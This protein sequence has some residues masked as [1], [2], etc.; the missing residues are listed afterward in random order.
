MLRNDQITRPMAAIETFGSRQRRTGEELVEAIP[1]DFPN[2]FRTIWRDL[3]AL[4]LAGFPS[5]TEHANGQT[6]R[7]LMGRR[8]EA[9]FSNTA[10]AW[11][12][13]SFVN[14]PRKTRKR[15]KACTI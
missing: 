9:E 4:E 12:K 11:S 3:E 7:R 14:Y 1:D 6:W 15:V 2:N 5:V 8:I 13:T 10:A